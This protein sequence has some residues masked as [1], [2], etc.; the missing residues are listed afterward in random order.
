MVAA[1]VHK[2]A[3]HPSKHWALSDCT[4]VSAMK[5]VLVR[6]LFF[7][8]SDGYHSRVSPGCPFLL[9]GALFIVQREAP[10]RKERVV[11]NFYAA[12]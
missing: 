11:P 5:L 3:R 1:R 9:G 4:A 12:K 7:W 6:I 10:T 2:Q 8:D